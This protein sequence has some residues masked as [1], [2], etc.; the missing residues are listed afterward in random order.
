LNI[1]GKVSAVFLTRWG[2]PVPFDFSRRIIMSF[3]QVMLLAALVSVAAGVV[4]IAHGRR[5]S[6]ARRAFLR[7]AVRTQAQVIDLIER[8]R[9]GERVPDMALRAGADESLCFPLVRFTL[10][11]G[12]TVT[13]ETLWGARPA[14]ARRG[15]TVQIDYDPANPQ[16]V[17][18][19]TGVLATGSGAVAVYM[20]LGIG[21]ILSGVGALAFWA[22]IKIVLKV[23]V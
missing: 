4:F 6:A 18:L 15:Q 10:P 13:A 8:T 22:L 3:T 9:Q 1:W 20:A 11:N 21:L 19:A 17:S 16:R 23:P 12:E 2:R 7:T 5:L 14:P